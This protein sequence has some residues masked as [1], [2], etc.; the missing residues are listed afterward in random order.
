MPTLG[1]REGSQHTSKGVLAWSPRAE[2]LGHRRSTR[3]HDDHVLHR[4]EGEREAHHAPDVRPRVH[5]CAEAGQG[6][7]QAVEHVGAV[8]AQARAR[9]APAELAV[10]SEALE[11]LVLEVEADHRAEPQVPRVDVVDPPQGQHDAADVDEGATMQVQDER[12]ADVGH[13]ADEEMSEAN[14]QQLR[15][16][17]GKQHDSRVRQPDAERCLP[18]EAHHGIQ[19]QEGEKG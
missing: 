18:S 2:S 16:A 10:A 8:P 4:C 19:W 13:H 9:G 5:V 14:S 15:E 11:D 17:L 3:A 6:E 7:A 12:D 1:V